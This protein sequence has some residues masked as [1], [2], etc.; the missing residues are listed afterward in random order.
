MPCVTVIKVR[1]RARVLPSVHG[2]ISTCVTT[3]TAA[4]GAM[5]ASHYAQVRADLQPFRIS[6]ESACFG[7]ATV[8]ST[9]NARS[10]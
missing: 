3:E 9:T 2:L 8:P 10:T 4:Q 1:M 5:A 6:S 7:S